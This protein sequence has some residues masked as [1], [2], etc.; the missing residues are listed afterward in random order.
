M[1]FVT[2]ETGKPLGGLNGA[3]MEVGASPAWTRYTAS[4]SLPVEII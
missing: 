4:L 1:E 3:G 2:R